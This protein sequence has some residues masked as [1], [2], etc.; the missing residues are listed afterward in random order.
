MTRTLDAAEAWTNA[1]IGLA[2]SVLTVQAAWPLFGWDATL[3]QSLA[4][5]AL[6]WAMS[7][8]RTYALRRV[9][10]RFS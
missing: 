5:T 9:F 3:S 7:V 8:V 10:R 1:T 2:L 4:V 6:F